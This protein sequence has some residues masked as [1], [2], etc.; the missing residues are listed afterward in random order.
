MQWHSKGNIKYRHKVSDEWP[1]IIW[2]STAVPGGGRG[3]ETHAFT[4]YQTI[5]FT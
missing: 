2:I 5:I 1:N 3:T 4:R